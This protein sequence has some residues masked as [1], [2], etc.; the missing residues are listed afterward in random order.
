MARGRVRTGEDGNQ[1]RD[2]DEDETE[3]L[4]LRYGKAAVRDAYMNV[5]S[6]GGYRDMMDA[7]RRYLEASHG[8]Q[9]LFGIGA[10][11]RQPSMDF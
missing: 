3:Y 9:D 10:L 7:V 1:Y 8:P 5:K 11:G 4:E 2:P 6:E